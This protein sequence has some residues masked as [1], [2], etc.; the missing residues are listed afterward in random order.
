MNLV[1]GVE[2]VAYAD[3]LYLIACDRSILRIVHKIILTLQQ[4]LNWG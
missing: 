2:L 1:D 4:I 3:D